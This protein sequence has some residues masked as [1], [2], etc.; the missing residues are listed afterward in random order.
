MNIFS[1]KLI[2]TLIIPIGILLSESYNDSCIPS[3]DNREIY[4]NEFTYPETLQSENFVIHY[5]TS[6]VDSQLV[7][8][9]LFSLQCNTGYAESILN[10]AQ[11]C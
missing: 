4:R 10:H 7:N 8:G 6:N 3:N 2:L 5:T 1:R 11:S 9:Q